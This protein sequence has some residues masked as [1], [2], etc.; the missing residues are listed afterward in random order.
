M[1]FIYFFYLI[2]FLIY[3]LGPLTS[4]TVNLGPSTSA[5]DTVETP[6]STT[7]KYCNTCSIM[8]PAN[9][10]VGHLRTLQH[11]SQACTTHEDE[12]VQ[13]VRTSFRNRIS[14]F[15]LSAKQDPTN[16]KRFVN[17]LK[18]KV[19]RLVEDHQHKFDFLKVGVELFGRFVLPTKETEEVKSFIAK[20]RMVSAGSDLGE[21]IDQVGDILDA[22]VSEF[23][24][25]DSGM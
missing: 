15:R 6:Q 17:N 10:W 20:Y 21:M 11:R 3:F 24:E 8:V 5:V 25:R 2:I 16:P 19:V 7:M 4:A 12:G 9:K 14:T 22:K 13:L 23:K 1:F 18:P